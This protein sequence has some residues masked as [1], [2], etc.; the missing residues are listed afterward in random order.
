MILY[1]L[2]ESLTY[3]SCS[4]PTLF[5]YTLSLPSSLTSADC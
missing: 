5:L 3:T 4:S 2:N 1:V